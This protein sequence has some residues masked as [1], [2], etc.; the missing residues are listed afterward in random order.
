[1]LPVHHRAQAATIRRL[2]EAVEDP[3][4][5]RRFLDVAAEYDKLADD[6]GRASAK[7]V[8]GS[9]IPDKARVAERR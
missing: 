1:M 3:K 7:L 8:V 2:A 9:D 5:R 4:D 6:A